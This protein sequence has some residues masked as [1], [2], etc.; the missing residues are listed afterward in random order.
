VGISKANYKA[1]KKQANRRQKENALLK[2][3]GQEWKNRN[4]T[5]NLRIGYLQRK[6]LNRFFRGGVEK[7]KRRKKKRKLAI[8]ERRT[9]V[10]GW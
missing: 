8:L 5:A 2:E 9:A 4:L 7:K 3:E 10:G 6:L 1:K